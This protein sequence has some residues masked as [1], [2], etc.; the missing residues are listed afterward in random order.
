MNGATKAQNLAS[1]SR[2]QSLSSQGSEPGNAAYD[3]EMTF[4]Q[5]ILRLGDK[6]YCWYQLPKEVHWWWI[7]LIRPL[8]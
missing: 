5:H 4:R 7:F 8:T 2:A 1:I 6:D 3:E